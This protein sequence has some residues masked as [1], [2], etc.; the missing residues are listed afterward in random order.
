V[1]FDKKHRF[2]KNEFSKSKF[3][4]KYQCSKNGFGKKYVP[5]RNMSTDLGW[6]V[7]RE[8]S[9]MVDAS[10]SNSDCSLATAST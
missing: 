1:L 3:S 8:P 9:D 7:A 10:L 2:S 5:V 4:K 6:A